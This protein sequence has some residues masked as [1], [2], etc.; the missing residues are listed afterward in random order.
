MG[1]TTLFE[2]M[3]RRVVL[4]LLFSGL[5]FTAIGVFMTP[6]GD[7]YWLAVVAAPLV[8]GTAGFILGGA[9]GRTLD[10][11]MMRDSAPKQAP[12]VLQ[13]SALPP[14]DRAALQTALLPL[15]LSE[16]SGAADRMSPREKAAARA[17]VEAGATAPEGEARQ[18][19]GHDLPRLIGAL[20][21]GRDAAAGEAEALARRLGQPSE[22]R[23]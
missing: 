17:L 20:A 22:R 16:L 8:G 6:S 21:T 23:P 10:A 11:W 2:D 13:P 18:V 4:A 9:P 12:T 3:P 1:A 7:G 15:L 14:S 19:L 5:F